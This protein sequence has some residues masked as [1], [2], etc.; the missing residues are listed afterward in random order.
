MKANKP[1]RIPVG[2]R[3]TIYVRGKKKTYVADFWQD[4]KHCRQSL[5]TS[6][7]KEAIKRAT[8]L[9]A[10]LDDGT[11]RRPAPAAR[12]SPAIPTGD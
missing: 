7:K 9:A 8:K 4:G 2:E 5:K 6:N 10:Q 3:V 11:F 12:P 1:D